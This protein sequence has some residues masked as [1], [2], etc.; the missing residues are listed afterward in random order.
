MWIYLQ[1][2]LTE[3]EMTSVY[4]EAN[5]QGQAQICWMFLRPDVWIG[6][7]LCAADANRSDMSTDLVKTK[8][9]FPPFVDMY[10]WKSYMVDSLYAVGGHTEAQTFNAE[11]FQFSRLVSIE[12]THS[13][14]EQCMNAGPRV[15]GPWNNWMQ[16]LLFSINEIRRTK[17]RAWKQFLNIYKNI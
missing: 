2:R 10:V 12:V 7:V 14:S 4:V 1:Y 8:L 16:M 17:R 13:R 9:Q 5:L 6:Y 15:N 11:P 3:D